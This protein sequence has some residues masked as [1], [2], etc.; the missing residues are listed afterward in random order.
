MGKVKGEKCYILVFWKLEKMGEY[1]TWERLE[2]TAECKDETNT[3]EKRNGMVMSTM[4]EHLWN[5]WY[6]GKA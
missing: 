5:V 2:E 3:A 6:W 1:S 4:E